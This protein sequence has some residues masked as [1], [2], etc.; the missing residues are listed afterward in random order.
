VIDWNT[1]LNAEQSDVNAALVERRPPAEV[2]R[3]AMS[4]ERR[5]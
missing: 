1:G 2:P 5:V 3:S 4:I